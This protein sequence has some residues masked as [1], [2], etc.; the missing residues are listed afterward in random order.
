MKEGAVTLKVLLQP[1]ASRDGIDGLMGDALK[2]RVTS[3]PLEGRANKAL[4]MFLAKR[5]G[6]SPSQVEIITGQ[7]SRGKLLRISGI[8]KEELE[9]ALGIGLPPL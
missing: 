3:P 1:R 8:S 6:L 9:R 7:R 5:L 2:V 4:R